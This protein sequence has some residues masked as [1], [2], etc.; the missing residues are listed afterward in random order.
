MR[1]PGTDPENVQMSDV[2]CDFCGREWAE[3]VAMLEGHHGSCICGPCLTTAYTDLVLEDRGVS[4][5]YTCA[6]CLEKPEDRAALDRGDEPGWRSAVRPDASAC[7]R[8][9]ELA[10][11]TLDRDRDFAWSKPTR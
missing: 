6:M 5:G 1:K 2:L 3:D 10:A 11:R 7:R 4:G 8:C 9:I